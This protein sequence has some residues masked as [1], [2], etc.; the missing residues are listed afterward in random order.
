MYLKVLENF[1]ISAVMYRHNNN[2]K[3]LTKTH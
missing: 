2:I 1:A 3:F